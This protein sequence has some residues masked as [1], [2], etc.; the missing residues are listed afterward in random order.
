MSQ[1]DID[2]NAVWPLPLEAKVSDTIL[3]SKNLEEID[4]TGSGIAAVSCGDYNSTVLLKAYITSENISDVKF[5]STVLFPPS[6]K[7][8]ESLLSYSCVLANFSYANSIQLQKRSHLNWTYAKNDISV[9]GEHI[10]EGCV[11]LEEIDLALNGVFMNLSAMVR[12]LPNLTI[13]KN[14]NMIYGNFT[15]NSFAGCPRLETVDLQSSIFGVRTRAPWV[16]IEDDF[17][18]TAIALFPEFPGQEFMNLNSVLVNNTYDRFF[19]S[20]CLF[21]LTQL[22]EFIIQG[23][24]LSQQTDGQYLLSPSNP[25]ATL[26]E[27]ILANKTGFFARGELPSFETNTELVTI[28]ISGLYVTGP[29]PD[30]S[31]NLNLK[32]LF[33]DSLRITDFI[34]INSPSLTELKIDNCPNLR[35]SVTNPIPAINCP[36]LTSLSLAQNFNLSGPLPNF[37]TMPL[38]NSI[39]L[40]STNFSSYQS[41]TLSGLFELKSFSAPETSLRV[42]DVQQIIKDIY[43]SYLVSPRTQGQ[44]DFRFIQ[45]V[46]LQSILSDGPTVVAYNTLVNIANWVILV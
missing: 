5:N 46:S 10:F 15:R 4:L 28:S 35:T 41:G 6:V 39:S 24:D 14:K 8:K 12:D 7:F 29:V 32:S 13:M 42:V 31:N 17:D 11:S 34:E 16:S 27:Q 43:S 23:T 3:G 45:G 30:I 20:D 2:G 9:E 36:L 1:E 22:V 33:L 37:A 21:D 44:M 40:Q 18:S 25:T 38:L 19:E 26:I